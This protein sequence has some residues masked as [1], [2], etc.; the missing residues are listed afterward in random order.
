MGHLF[1]LSVLYF[2]STVGLLGWSYCQLCPITVYAISQDW[3]YNSSVDQQLV[4]QYYQPLFAKDLVSFCNFNSMFS[5]HKDILDNIF[6]NIFIYCFDAW[7]ASIAVLL[8]YQLY[9]VGVTLFPAHS[10]LEV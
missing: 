7:T 8:K 1:L 4:F 9:R 2:G 10:Q 6:I 5:F 3:F